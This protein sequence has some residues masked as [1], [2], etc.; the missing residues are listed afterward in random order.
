[1]SRISSSEEKLLLFKRKI[2][3]I[4]QNLFELYPILKS[5][6]SPFFQIYLVFMFLM[7]IRSSQQ[8]LSTYSCTIASTAG[9]P[10]FI[11]KVCKSS[12]N[13]PK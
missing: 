10:E 7:L 1:M 2:R 13:T 5:L 6:F 8:V 9:S 12:G 11:N 4:E 3:S